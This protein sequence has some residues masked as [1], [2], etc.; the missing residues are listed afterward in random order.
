MRRLGRRLVVAYLIVGA[1]IAVTENVWGAVAGGPTALV[2]TGSLADNARLVWWWLIVPALTWPLDLY[3][4]VYH[5]VG[6][7]IVV[8]D[9]PSQ[10]SD[11]KADDP[12]PRGFTARHQWN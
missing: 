1:I 2:W 6:R 7:L 9:P 12:S 3:W 4:A 8:S 11:L 10:I 5:S